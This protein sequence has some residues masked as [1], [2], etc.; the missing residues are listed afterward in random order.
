MSQPL[1]GDAFRAAA[2]KLY[3]KLRT[4]LVVFALSCPVVGWLVG[5]IWG[6]V[7]ATVLGWSLS[8]VAA[9]GIMFFYVLS[10]DGA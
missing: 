5:G 3:H 10:Q 7:L 9:F 1:Q 2:T 8:F 4:A 6:L